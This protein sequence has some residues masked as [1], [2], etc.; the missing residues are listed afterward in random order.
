MMSKMGVELNVGRWFKDKR[1]VMEYVLDG[2]TLI[3]SCVF[4]VYF[5]LYL[6]VIL[7]V[8]EVHFMV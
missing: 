7:C 5:T 1:W 8:F 3:L 4:V 6:N 2:V